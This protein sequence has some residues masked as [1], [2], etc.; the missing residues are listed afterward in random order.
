MCSEAKPP[1]ENEGKR[2]RKWVAIKN[3]ASSLSVS[4]VA[5]LPSALACVE[6]GGKKSSLAC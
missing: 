4:L 1:G 3:G 5:L 2:V 6:D